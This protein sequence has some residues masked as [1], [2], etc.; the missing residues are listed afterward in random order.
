[1]NRTVL[2]SILVVLLVSAG[3]AQ[4]QIPTGG[5]IPDRRGFNNSVDDRKLT[6][7]V[8]EVVRRVAGNVYVIAGAGG[9]I[10][11]QSGPDGLFL[12]DDN[13]AVFYPRIEAALRQI[14]EKPVRIIVNTHSHFDHNQNNANFAR[15]GALIVAHP[16]LRTALMQQTRPPVAPEGLPVVTASEPLTF[17]F[18]GEDI[19]Y[20]PL[21]PSHTNGDVAVYFRGSDVFAFGDVFTTDYPSIGVAQGGSIEN[22]V[23][24]YNLALQTTTPNTIFVPGHAQLSKR[25]DVIAVRDAITVIHGRFL[26]MVKKG[27]TLEQIRQ[28]RPSREFDARFATENF[29]PNEM[30]NSTRWY[31]QM[32]DEAKAHLAQ[33]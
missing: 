8:E 14:S 7:P 25:V 4:S 16:N 10:V 15:Q 22:F 2:A 32:F 9:N 12:V 28:A 18:N 20:I 3:T 27:M 24:N 21:K 6:D 1:M 33:R 23:D 31:Q 13:F 30:Q 11:A 26:D 29:A 5:P 17:H 19:S